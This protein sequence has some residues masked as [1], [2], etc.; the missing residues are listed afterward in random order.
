MSCWLAKVGQRKRRC[1]GFWA[2][3]C[4]KELAERII[5]SFASSTFFKILQKGDKN[6][7]NVLLDCILQSAAEMFKDPGVCGT[8]TTL[9]EKGQESHGVQSV[10]DSYGLIKSIINGLLAL[11][12]P[13]PETLG[14]S[15]K[16]VA[17]LTDP[18]VKFTTPLFN[19]MKSSI[20]ESLVENQFWQ[21][22]INET[23]R[24]A[25]TSKVHAPEIQEQRKKLKKYVQASAEST[26]V[27]HRAGMQIV[28]PTLQ[29]FSEL[30]KKLKTGALDEL[31]NAVL[32]AVRKLTRFITSATDVTCEEVPV[33]MVAPLIEGL[34]S[35]AAVVGIPEAVELQQHLEAWYAKSE[36]DILRARI[37]S[38]LEGASSK[39]AAATSGGA[40]ELLIDW[41]LL[42]EE[43]PKLPSLPESL[44][45]AFDSAMNAIAC[46]LCCQAGVGEDKAAWAAWGLGPLQQ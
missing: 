37:Q 22:A 12:T 31:Q 10:V 16:D 46:D 18:S 25:A 11:L 38:S 27:D 9:A 34:E 42:A 30:H 43:V 33:D 15:A 21:E 20:E 7:Y 4:S 35:F 45:A 24:T 41:P 26:D 40:Q 39:L 17:N 44:I 13:L 14:L 29:G 1:L 5:E 2:A 8:L 36:A 6:N 32:Q 23:Q 28:V 19:S 3:T